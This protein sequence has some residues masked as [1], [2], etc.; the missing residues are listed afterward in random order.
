MKIRIIRSQRR[1]M[2]LQVTAAGEVVV[3]CPQSITQAEIDRM[4]AEKREWLLRQ[5][6]NMEAKRAAVLTAS[7]GEEVLLGAVR[8]VESARLAAPQVSAGAL[9]YPVTWTEARRQQYRRELLHRFCEREIPLAAA[10]LRNL[11]PERD[12]WPSGAFK[13]RVMKRRWGS[14]AQ[15]GDLLFN[16]RLVEAAPEAIRYVIRHELAHWVHFNHSKAFRALEVQLVGGADRLAEAK[17]GLA[18]ISLSGSTSGEA[19][20]LL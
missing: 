13:L 4:L 11:F 9:V 15:N 18:Q 19:D 6:A 1:T 16:A 3:R 7:A 10:A 14:C 17:A 5:L 8:K 2:S 12:K 20:D